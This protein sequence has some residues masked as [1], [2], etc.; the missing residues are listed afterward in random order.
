MQ[1]HE[2]VFFECGFAV[3]DTNAVVMAVEAVDQSLDGGLV[4]MTEI[5][6]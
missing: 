4:E 5:G 3:V 1:V 2:H 6:G